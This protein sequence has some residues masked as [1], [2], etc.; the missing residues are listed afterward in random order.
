[1]NQAA[2]NEIDAL[3]ERKYRSLNRY[4]KPIRPRSLLRDCAAPLVC[5]ITFAVLTAAILHFLP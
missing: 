2:Q 1:M 4:R 3:R 5:S